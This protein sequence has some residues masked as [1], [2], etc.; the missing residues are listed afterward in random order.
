[1]ESFRKAFAIE[2]PG[3]DDLEPIIDGF[4]LEAKTPPRLPFSRRDAESACRSHPGVDSV[5]FDCS[6]ELIV[7]LVG[8]SPEFN[9]EDVI[10][11]LKEKI[12]IGISIKVKGI[13]NA[14]P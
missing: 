2:L 13:H 10:S 4:S 12:P 1:M 14:A 11:Y 9:S 3:L 8:I 5:D 6:Q 7:I